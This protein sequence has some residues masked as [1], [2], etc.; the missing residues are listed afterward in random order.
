MDQILAYAKEKMTEYSDSPDL[1]SKA[2]EASLMA[3]LLAPINQ[4]TSILTLLALDNYQPLLVLQ[5]FTTRRAVAHAV[6]SSILKNETVI[7]TPDDVYGVL[8][9]C[10]V[11]LCDQKDAPVATTTAT[12]PM[13]ARGKK[14][15]FTSI[16]EEEYMEEQG[17]IAKMVHLFKSKSEDTQFLVSYM[18]RNKILHKE[19]EIKRKKLRYC[20]DSNCM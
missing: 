18:K 3:L 6:I 16:E 2:T 12:S 11:L 5:P 8:E 17:W 20:M 4:Y 14:P 15:E 9:L 1:H 7:S 10:Q 13:Y 19:R